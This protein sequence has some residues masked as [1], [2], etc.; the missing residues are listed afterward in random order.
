M[1]IETM[2][3]LANAGK[4]V[5]LAVGIGYFAYFLGKSHTLIFQRMKD[6]HVDDSEREMVSVYFVRR[7]A[8]ILLVFSILIRSFLIGDHYENALEIAGQWYALLFALSELVLCFAFP[9]GL[10]SG[11]D[12]AFV[13][14][15]RLLDW[16]YYVPPARDT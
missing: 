16:N 8:L 11:T 5:L 9:V 7:A 6:P 15:W 10:C 3:L 2:A 14:P 1:G 4:F 12:N 13:P